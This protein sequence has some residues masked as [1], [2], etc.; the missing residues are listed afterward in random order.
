MTRTFLCCALLCAGTAACAVSTKPVRI[1][2]TPCPAGEFP[3]FI[4][5]GEHEAAPGAL[6]TLKVSEHRGHAG[7]HSLPESCRPL[8]SLSAGAPASISRADGVLQIAPDAP[9]G[10][11]FRVSAEL[12]DRT[13]ETAV[14]VVD[15]LRNPLVGTWKQ[16]AGTP[17]DSTMHV[18]PAEEG[19]RELIFRANGSFTVTWFPFESYTDYWGTYAYQGDSGGLSL[20]V[21]GGNHVP[22]NLDPEGIARFPAPRELELVDLSLG[23][24]TGSAIAFCRATFLRR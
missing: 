15:P 9:D 17:C 5:L 24:R 14:R 16:S 8:W 11:V 13:V 18:P 21:T 4:T 12:D 3:L 10:V 1:V 6:D 19:V 20:Q 22:G 7:P 2:E 23:S